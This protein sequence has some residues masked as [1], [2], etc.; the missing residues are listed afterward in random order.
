[1]K[2][3]KTVLAGAGLFILFIG[4]VTLNTLICQTLPSWLLWIYP[5]CW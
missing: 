1:V 2:T 3:L 5:G 4:V